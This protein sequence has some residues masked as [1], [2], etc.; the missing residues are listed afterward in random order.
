MAS[1]PMKTSAQ[2]EYNICPGCGK[3]SSAP[4]RE[5]WKHGGVGWHDACLGQPPLLSKHGLAAALDQC[6]TKH[7]E[8]EVMAA[9]DRLA[10]NSE[11]R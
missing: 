3:T 9:Y 11:D 6:K 4:K 8:L 1:Q 7:D 10:A 5:G 2:R